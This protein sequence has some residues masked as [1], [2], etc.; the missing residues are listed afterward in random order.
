VLASFRTE[1]LI[2]VLSERASQHT[3]ENEVFA[4]DK[5]QPVSTFRPWRNRLTSIATQTDRAITF[6]TLLTNHE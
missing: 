2:H 6:L 4:F 1:A 5:A 3:P